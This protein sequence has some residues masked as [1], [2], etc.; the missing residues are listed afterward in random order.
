MDCLIPIE[1]AGTQ[2]GSLTYPSKSA[3]DVFHLPGWSGPV[4]CDRI[5]IF[6]LRELFIIDEVI[7]MKHREY[8]AILNIQ[9]MIKW[10]TS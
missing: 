5:D 9:V 4:E 10:Y 7:E 1:Q 8:A 2:W 3:A 6:K